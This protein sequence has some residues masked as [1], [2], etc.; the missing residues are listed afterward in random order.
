MSRLVPR[1]LRVGDVAPSFHATSL[2]TGHSVRVPDVTR[3]HLTFLS[4]WARSCK[5]CPMQFTELDSL[6]RT[7]GPR[8]LAIVAVSIDP[9]VNASV[10]DSVK[11]MASSLD[12]A[13]L[14]LHD[15]G[16]RALRKYRLGGTPEALLLDSEGRVLYRL[17]GLGVFHADRLLE[18]IELH[19]RPAA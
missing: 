11:T 15:A 14:T 9:L 13:V 1:R 10:R 16:D 5:L 6:A 8:G 17:L 19:L 7:Y 2:S 3:G 18:L 4:F 12:S